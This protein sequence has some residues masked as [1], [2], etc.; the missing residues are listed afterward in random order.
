MFLIG[1]CKRKFEITVLSKFCRG[2]RRMLQFHIYCL[3]LLKGALDDRQIR[4][5]EVAI[6]NESNTIVQ[7]GIGHLP[8]RAPR[9]QFHLSPETPESNS[10]LTSDPGG[11]F[12]RPTMAAG[13]VLALVAG[14]VVNGVTSLE[15]MVSVLR[16]KDV[17]EN[18]HLQ[19]PGGLISNGKVSGIG[20]NGK[21][22]NVPEAH[23]NWFRV[24]IGDCRTVLGG[25]VPDLLG[26]PAVLGLARLQRS[27]ALATVFSPAYA[28]FALA[29]R[30]QQSI[31]VNNMSREETI[32]QAVVAAVNDMVAHEP[33]RDVCLRDTTALYRCLSGD[34]GESKYAAVLDAQQLDMY[35]K[36]SAMVPLRARLFLHA[37]L[38]RKMP[39]DDMQGQNRSTNSNGPGQ[40]EQVVQVLIPNS[41]A[42]VYI[43]K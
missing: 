39:E 27:M 3:Q 18:L 34:S 11:A 33:F 1:L 26:E 15:R 7:A 14:L 4:M 29:L 21:A 9:S 23:I 2:G 25:L 12:G 32:I 31:F 24:L 6:A 41:Y 36:V 10:A 38:D 16:V 35:K 43:R 40:I 5:L 17:L 42:L 37:L 28:L 22:E 30:R 13:A 8:G 19:K 20:G